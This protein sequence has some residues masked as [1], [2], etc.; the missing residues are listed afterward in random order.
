MYKTLITV[1][2]QMEKKLENSQLWNIQTFSP[3]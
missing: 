3:D 2:T 1:V